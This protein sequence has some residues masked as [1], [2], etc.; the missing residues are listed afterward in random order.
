MVSWI[1]GH[2]ERFRCL[3]AHAGDFDLAASYFDT[4]ELWFPEWEMGG[5]PF[6]RE[7]EYRKWSPSR[8]AARWRTPELVTHGELDYRVAVGQAISTFTALQRR[9]VES[10][11]V[12]FPD[13]GHHL[14]KPRSARAFHGEVFGW[15]RAHIG[16][17]AAAAEGR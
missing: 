3:V 14:L 15:I 1:N 9:G 8:F 5:T 17:I 6:D 13:E 2:S 4:E 10:R 12:I 7:E 16:P 11:L